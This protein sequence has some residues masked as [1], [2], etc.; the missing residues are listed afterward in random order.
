M[1]TPGEHL[2]VAKEYDLK[3]RAVANQ[4]AVLHRGKIDALA[5]VERRCLAEHG[6]HED[7]GSFFRGFCSRCGAYLG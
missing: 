2:R 7:D 4:L 6:S 3:I 1:M 5:E